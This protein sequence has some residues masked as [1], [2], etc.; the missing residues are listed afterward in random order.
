MKKSLQASFLGLFLIG[1]VAL[2]APPN[3][4]FILADD[5]SYRDM[6]LYGGPAK[7]P[8]MNLLAKQGMKFNRCYQSAPMCSPTRHA[9]YT[10]LYPVKSGAYPNHTRAY[11]NVRSIVHH[12]K[13]LGYRVVQTGK[14]HINPPEVFPFER[15]QPNGK[16]PNMEKIGELFAET[17]AG[18]APSPLSPPIAD[19]TA[20]TTRS[21]RAPAPMNALLTRTPRFI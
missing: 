21:T 6:E 18:G 14:T 10:G 5:C 3:F 13:P 4:V 7:T 9:L 20:M 11:P 2:G 1:G 17:A 8:H 19:A 15:P 16:N 12:L